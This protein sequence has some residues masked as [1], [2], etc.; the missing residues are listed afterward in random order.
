MIRALFDLLKVI[1]LVGVAVFL[2]SQPGSVRLEWRDYTVTMPT[3]V[4]LLIGLA[5]MVFVS[6]I[7]WWGN[8]VVRW[9]KDLKRR[10]QDRR[11]ARGHQALVRSISAS[12]AGDYKQA[13]TYAQRAEKLLPDSESALPLLL[14]AQ[15][16][17]WSGRRDDSLQAYQSLL[18]YEDSS[19]LGLK[20][21]MQHSMDVGDRA[22]ALLFARE[23]V[24]R[25]PGQALLMKSVYDL[26]IGN[27]LWSDALV[28]AKRLHGTKVIEKSKLSSDEQVLYLILAD[29]ALAED[30]KEESFQA[31]KHAYK[32]DVY[33]VPAVVRLASAYIQRGKILTARQIVQK[34]WKRHAHPDLIPVW[35]LLLPKAKGDAGLARLKWF[36]WILS[37]NPNSPDGMLAVAQAAIDAGLW[38]EARVFLSRAEK[39][40]PSAKL[41]RLWA[42]LEEMSS[43]SETAKV[44]LE[45]AQMAAPDAAWICSKTGRRFENWIA[46]VEPEGYFNTV[47]WAEAVETGISVVSEARH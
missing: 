17:E 27:R 2:V 31:L 11:R 3:G 4:L 46:V 24:E 41:Y 9:P 20:G 28:S 22:Q 16:A 45:K 10:I 25:Q 38:G 6:T 33:F 1:L 23:A 40:R 32:R 30:R 21:L 44:W 19:F 26:E 43:R 39:I 12:S 37:L 7:T 36:E 13:Y 34:A 35:D 14:K 15:A 5:L 18:G 42:Y 29:Q 47:I 8:E